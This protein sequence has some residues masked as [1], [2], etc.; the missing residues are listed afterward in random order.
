[1]NNEMN[2]SPMTRLCHNII[3]T[4][5][6]QNNRAGSI[7]GTGSTGVAGNTGNTGSTGFHDTLVEKSEG[8]SDTRNMNGVLVEDMSMEEYKQYIYD[9]IGALPVHPSNMQDSISVHISDAGFEAMKND[10]EYEKWVLDSIKANFQYPDPWSGVSGGKFTVFYF[11]A[12]KE[13]SRSES[14]RM[15]FRNGDGNKLFNEKSEDS[16][17]ERRARRRKQLKKELEEMQEKKAIAKQMAKSQYFAEL[18]AIK[19]EDGK[20]S[21]PMNYDML[22][23]QI[24]STFKTNIILESLR[25]KKADK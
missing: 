5:Q 14:W 21:E 25:G 16:F 11:G 4:C 8:V 20:A 24:F 19:P 1:M 15:G 2:F 23:M 7:Y 13:E 18:A 9:R 22:A 10:P 17:W 3:K 12:T 6:A